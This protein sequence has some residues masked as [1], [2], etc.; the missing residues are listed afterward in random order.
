MKATKQE[1]IDFLEEKVLRP[2]ED[3]P[4][5][6]PTIKKKIKATRMRLNNQRS[7]EKVEEY[8]WHAMATDRGIDSY[9]KMKAIGSVTFEDVRSEFKRLCGRIDKRFGS[10][11]VMNGTS[12]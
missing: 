7:A 10:L 5:A 3:H 11:T 1:L 6:T 8:F 12:T 2:G 9:S 4:D